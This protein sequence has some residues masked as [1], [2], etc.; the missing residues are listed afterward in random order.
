MGKTIQY[1]Q[2]GG[3]FDISLQVTVPN[4]WQPMA[5]YNIGVTAGI[6]TTKIAPVWVEKSLHMDKIIVVSEHAKFG[7]D[8]TEYEATNNATG[9][10][11][12]AKSCCP[13]EVV[14]YPV[15][16]IEPADIELKLESDFN[17]LAVGT[18]IVRKNLENTVKWF[19]EE[20][21]EQKGLP[22]PAL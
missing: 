5:P 19:V 1:T 21:Y 17:F 10:E 4:E 15:K 22:V 20:F 18:W 13:I 14:H 8:N 12:M 6:E 16:N 7:F 2:Q 3:Q 11:F 9:D